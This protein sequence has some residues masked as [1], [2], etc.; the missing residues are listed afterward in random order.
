[1]LMSFLNTGNTTAILREALLLPYATHYAVC[2]VL[3]ALIGMGSLSSRH[4]L[5]T[6]HNA[7]SMKIIPFMALADSKGRVYKNQLRIRDAP[8]SEVQCQPNDNLSRHRLRV[9]RSL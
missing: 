4:P 7:S 1:M 3:A 2:H 5:R 6:L 8:S 9:P